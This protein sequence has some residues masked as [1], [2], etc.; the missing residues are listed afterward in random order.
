MNPERINN[1]VSFLGNSRPNLGPTQPPIQWVSG[2][3]SEVGREFG[4]SP[5][6]SA[7]VRMRRALPLLPPYVFIS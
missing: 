2:F 1:F 5:L 4:H 6:C 3:F 7:K